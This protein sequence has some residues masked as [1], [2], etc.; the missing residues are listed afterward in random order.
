M[1]KFK[2]GYYLELLPPESMKLI[3]S[4]KSNITK[5]IKMVK[6]CII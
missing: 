6:M 1:F 4:T 2:T 3:E 5:K